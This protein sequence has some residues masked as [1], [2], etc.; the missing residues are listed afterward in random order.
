MYPPRDA[1]RLQGDKKQTMIPNFLGRKTGHHNIPSNV[2]AQPY[3]IMFFFLFLNQE[4]VR[5]FLSATNEYAEMVGTKSW[6]ALKERE[7]LAFIVIIIFMGVVK[8]PE[9][10]M[11]W[12]KDSFGQDFLRDIISARRS[13]QILSHWHWIVVP[14]SERAAAKAADPFYLVAGFVERMA[15]IS[16]SY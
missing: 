11:Y 14:E 12:Q 13:E 15:E 16:R 2:V 6:K 9:R 8:L 3:P 5:Q 4:I 7:F 1:I 10:A